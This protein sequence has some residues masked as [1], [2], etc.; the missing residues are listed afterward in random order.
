MKAKFW[1][2]LFE[3]INENQQEIFAVEK[4]IKSVHFCTKSAEFHPVVLQQTNKTHARSFSCQ[5][6]L[7]LHLAVYAK[8]SS[9]SFRAY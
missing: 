4:L 7:K 1:Q 9:S 8:S 3:G 5:L 6:K 2:L